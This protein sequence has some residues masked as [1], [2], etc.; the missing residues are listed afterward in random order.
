V[1][2]WRQRV[3]IIRLYVCVCVFVILKFLVD[4]YPKAIQLY[5]I[6]SFLI[7]LCFNKILSSFRSI[8][9]FVQLTVAGCLY[10]CVCCMFLC[11]HPLLRVI[12]ITISSYRCRDAVPPVVRVEAELGRGFMWG[13]MC[14]GF[15]ILSISLVYLCLFN[16]P[17][18]SNYYRMYLYIYI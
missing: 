6:N 8:H 9:M 15:Y 14:K 12:I 13:F 2:H 1:Q 4:Y 3:G 11:F 5:P 7:K 18:I 10:V 17:S 16:F